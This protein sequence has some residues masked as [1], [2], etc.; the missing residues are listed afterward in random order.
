MSAATKAVIATVLTLVL[1]VVLAVVEAEYTH[2]AITVG[3]MVTCVVGAIGLLF[4]VA[5]DYQ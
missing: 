3:L 5:F 2:G 1:I 4:Y